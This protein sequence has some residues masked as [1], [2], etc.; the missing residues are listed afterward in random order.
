MVDVSWSLLGLSLNV[1]SSEAVSHHPLPYTLAP[2]IRNTGSSS[3]NH[4]GW[5]VGPMEMR[6]GSDSDFFVCVISEK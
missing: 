5:W 1:T 6:A 3:Q 4:R 2:Q